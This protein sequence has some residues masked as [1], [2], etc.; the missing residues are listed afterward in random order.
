VFA[1][2]LDTNV[3]WPSLR[4]DFLLSMAIEGLY[5]PLWSEA[6]LAELHHHEA[7]KLLRRG[8][9]NAQAQM[10]AE[11]LTRQMRRHFADAI[12]TGWEPLEGSYGL[13]DPDDEHVLAAAVMGGAGALVT[14]NSKHFP[15]Q[16]IPRYVHVLSAAEFA[17]DTIS[18]NPAR[19]VQALEEMSRRRTNPTQTPNQL[20]DLLEVRYEMGEAADLL[21]DALE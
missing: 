15:A 3:V 10:Q 13:P 4:R 14:E 20:V 12:V 8:M 17:R 5:R 9:S 16:Q 7:K 6:I 21:R 18:V 1:A 19:A 2:L 11:H